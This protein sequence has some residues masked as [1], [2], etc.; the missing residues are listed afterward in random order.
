MRC[1]IASALAL[2]AVVPSVVQ[3]AKAEDSPQ[4]V[5][6]QLKWRHQ[7][8]FA[9]YYA[10][11]EQ[12]F[13][14]Q[15]G[16]DVTIREGSA[17]RAPLPE[18]LAGKVEYAVTGADVLEARLNGEAVVVLAVIFQHSPYV[19]LTRRDR[20][21]SRLDQLI[22]RTV[23]L[24]DHQGATEFKA[25]MLA[26]GL[27]LGEV[28][29]VEH[30]W[31]NDDLIDGRVDAISAYVSVEPHQI[32][33]RGVEV[34]IIRPV[35]YGID[36]YGDSLVTTA[37]EVDEH[38]ARAAA[39]RR[40]T[41]RGWEY[42]FEHVD[43]MIQLILAMPGTVDRGLTAEGLRY[44][45][46]SMRHLALPHLIEIGHM[47]PG[48]W[49]RMADT[50]VALGLAP[51]YSSLDGFLYDAQPPSDP[52]PLWSALGAVVVLM[53]LGALVLVWN[54]QL[55]RVVR[56]RTAEL[57]Q[58]AEAIGSLN[59]ALEG[60]VRERT[61]QLEVANRELEAFAYSVSHDLRA[62]LR[63]LRGYASI[64]IEDHGAEFAGPARAYV[65]R[66]GAA[67][68]QMND[69]V[70]ALL[71]LSNLSS[72]GMSWSSVDLSALA[73]DV[74]AELRRNQPARDVSFEIAP[75]VFVE[76]D[77]RLLRQAMRNLLENAWKYTS[78]HPRAHIEFGVDER[79]AAPPEDNGTCPSRVFYVRDDGAGFDGQHADQLFRPFR[80][81]HAPSEFEGT[82]IG[83]ATVQRIIQRHRGRI[84]AEAAPEK[85]ATF[86]FTLAGANGSGVEPPR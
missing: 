42:A 9:G 73:A 77:P 79:A 40:A 67:A 14:A 30:S 53:L 22:G 8:Q 84:W 49:R 55:R 28:R 74:A 1:A 54:R 33:S 25:M 59:T 34:G 80:R 52:V 29:L 69:V 11:L 58:A 86:Y 39:M 24:H 60:R 5:T 41:L 4:R 13:F 57:E 27:S 81:M 47:N 50:Y 83:L 45:A 68:E 61:A 51:T 62:P 17:E 38:P 20:G 6:L 7:F 15:E 12:G 56:Q 70:D 19:L 71:G 63:H 78:K 66:I 48:R 72:S 35:D 21:L 23:M 16:L 18:L 43:Q 26:E 44:E 85:G 37:A 36:F 65:D 75:E 10:A 76:G 32:Q 2:L 82:G 3:R 64:L 46:D 31:N